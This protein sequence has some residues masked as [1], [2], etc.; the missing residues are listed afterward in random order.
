[1]TKKEIKALV[2]KTA[3]FNIWNSQST[4]DEVLKS[5][6]VNLKDISVDFKE[7]KIDETT[8]DG[9]DLWSVV[10][11]VDELSA[12]QMYFDM[13][14]LSKE[15]LMYLNFYNDMLNNGMNTKNRSE[16]VVMDDVT[17]F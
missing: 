9:V 14:H 10:A 17:Y 1:M 12:V 16:M 8:V 4:S 7:R 13:S 2:K 15:K 6:A 3:D 5:T 11:D